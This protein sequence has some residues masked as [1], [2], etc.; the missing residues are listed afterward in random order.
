[1]SPEGSDVPPDAAEG[2]VEWAREHDAEREQIEHLRRMERRGAS[3]VRIQAEALSLA[4]FPGVAGR[5]VVDD[6]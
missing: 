5:R 2:F 3:D 4:M 6:V 1:M